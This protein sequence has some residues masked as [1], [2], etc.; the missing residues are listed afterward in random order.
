MVNG[1]I[2]CRN[3]LHIIKRTKKETQSEGERKYPTD[4]I[5]NIKFNVCELTIKINKKEMKEFFQKKKK[6]N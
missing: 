5:G 4:I 6:K 3:C 2:L 1:I